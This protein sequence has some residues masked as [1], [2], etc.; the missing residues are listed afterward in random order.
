MEGA[1]LFIRKSYEKTNGEYP[2]YV[3]VTIGEKSKIYSTKVS[4][5]E[6][7]W[8]PVKKIVKLKDPLHIEKNMVL[9]NA[10]SKAQKIVYKYQLLEM[11]L[12]FETFEKEYLFDE[13][14]NGSQTDYFQFAENELR[15]K[16]KIWC[17]QHFR[18]HYYELQKLKKF[19]NEVIIEKIDV[20]F[21]D[22]YVHYMTVKL[23]N[24]INTVNKTLKKMKTILNIAVQ[25]N[26]IEKNP[27]VNY[28][29]KSEKTHRVFLTNEELEKLYQFYFNYKRDDKYK[30]VLH[31]FLFACY[32]GLR[33]SDIEQLKW[34]HIIENQI[35]LVQHKTNEL[36]QIPLSEN[37]ISLL[38]EKRSEHIFDVLSNQKSNEYLKILMEKAGIEK[39]VSFH[40]ARHT[41]ATLSLEL[42]INLRVV[43]KLLGHQKIST[44]QIYTA[45][46][47][48]VLLNEMKKWNSIH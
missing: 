40:T 33:Y 37:A 23:N 3:K 46:T 14:V 42:G 21:I 25:K 36:V 39:D 6:K 38:P 31:Y 1:I 16:D 4:V 11:N 20:R 12:N 47:D 44:T 43:Q 35:Y 26:V 19:K 13:K 9:T 7:F 30:T 29:I 27:F 17:Y 41:F 5:E 15:L 10:L 34:N 18:Q 24:K 32:T 45:V 22:E 2:V 48:K 28:K 8:D